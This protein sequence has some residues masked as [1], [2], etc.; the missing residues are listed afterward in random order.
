MLKV[1]YIKESKDRNILILGVA[2]DED[3]K[4]YRVSTAL[5][6]DMGSPERG[7]S[8]SSDALEEVI[9]F[10]ERYRAEKKALSLLA[11]ADNNRQGLFN[12]L[13][14]AG[15][16]KDVCEETVAKMLSLGYIREEDQL[17]RLILAE[18]KKY[19]GPKKI[20]AKLAGKGY[21]HGDISR[22]ISE[23]RDSGDIDF[24]AI[25]EE[26]ISLKFPDGAEYEEKMKLLYKHGF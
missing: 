15:F 7:C 19:S 18:A 3:K 26:L 10:D 14:A 2:E 21:A 13:K 23:L 25:R 16:H 24:K 17:R 5:Y 1:I 11:I 8:L 4:H 20:M 6:A 12:K 22:V 9:A